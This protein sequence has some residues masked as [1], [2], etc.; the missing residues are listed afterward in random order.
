MMTGDQIGLVQD[1]FAQVLPA[2]AGAAHGFYGRLF[3]L[4]PETRAMFRG[5]MEDQGRKLFLTLATV[6]DALD[7]LDH[8]IPVAR[9]LAIRH[10]GYGVEERH[11][12]IVGEAL[13][14]TLRDVLST[15]FDPA[16]EEAWRSAY[17]VLASVMISASK[18]AVSTTR[19]LAA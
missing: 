7:Q 4:A 13:V 15:R 5:D 17:S 12:V 3:A 18:E 2:A 19:S 16:T 6:V 11:Y 8:V 9:A 14:E 10:V 1:S